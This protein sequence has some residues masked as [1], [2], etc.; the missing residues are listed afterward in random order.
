M[1][2]CAWSVFHAIVITYFA[3]AEFVVLFNSYIAMFLRFHLRFIMIN[4]CTA[5]TASLA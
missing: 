2:H 3:A 5:L 1:S 4:A